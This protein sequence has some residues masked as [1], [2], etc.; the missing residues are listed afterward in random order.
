MIEIFED[1]GDLI[2]GN[3]RLESLKHFAFNKDFRFARRIKMETLPLEVQSM[4]FFEGTKKKSIKGYL[5]KKETNPNILG[6]IYDY[7]YNSD[8][9]KKTTTIFQ[10]SDEVFDL[11]YFII[12]P[13]SSFSRIGSIFSSS[14][15]SDV[16]KEFA[17]SFSVESTDMNDMRMMITIQFA[18]LMLSIKEFTVEGQGDHLFIYKKNNIIDIVDMDN[19]YDYGIQLVD[20]ILNDQS[21]EMV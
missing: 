15:W 8:F 10:Y 18:E 4:E 5:Y 20:I 6:R 11:P 14:E 7:I 13:K 2:F 16:N 19:V 9:G 1:I 21:N 3:K 12:K 17:K